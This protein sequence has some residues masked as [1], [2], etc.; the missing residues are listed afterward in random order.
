MRLFKPAVRR[1]RKTSS[2]L[3]Y[4][5]IKDSSQKTQEPNKF[6]TLQCFPSKDLS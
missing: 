2:V 3:A 1:S 5:D 6:T 4:A